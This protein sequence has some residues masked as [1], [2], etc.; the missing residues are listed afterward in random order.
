MVVIEAKEFKKKLKCLLDSE[1]DGWYTIFIYPDDV[2]MTAY[3]EDKKKE[4]YLKKE[5]FKQ[6]YKKYDES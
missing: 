1:R 6:I 2:W 5:V 4:Y 3:H